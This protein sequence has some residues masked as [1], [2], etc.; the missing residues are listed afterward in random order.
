MTLT[1]RTSIPL[2]L[3]I[4]TLS[5]YSQAAEPSGQ[6]SASGFFEG[7]SLSLST[8]NFAA[9]ERFQGHSGLNIPKDGG[10]QFTQSR[11]TWVQGT[12]LKYNSG[13]T[14]GTVGFGID[15]AAFNAINLER[16]KGRIAGGGNRTLADSNGHGQEHW[17][18]LGIANLRARISRSELKV[19]RF[20]VETPV[21]NAIDNRALPSSFNGVGLVSEELDNLNLQAGSFRRT[22]P[23]TGAGDEALTTEYGTRQAEGER[24]N[25][26]GGNYKALDNLEV[27]LYGGR[28]E[29]IWDQYY[30]GITHDLGDREQLSLRTAF[31]GYHTR[32][33]GAREAGYIDNNTW[34]LAFTLGHQAHGLTLA[35]QQV[36]GDEYF[37]YVHETSA[38]YL[39]NSLLSDY[40][41]PNEKSAQIRYETDWSYFGIPGLSTMAW[42]A[43]GW[44]I[45]GTHYD[46]GRNGAHANYADVLSQDGEKHRE[47]GL[48]ASY[49]VQSGAIKDSTF[50]VTYMSHK[51]SQNQADGS[52]NEL[53]IVSTL[54]FDLL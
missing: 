17:S 51:A 39:A 9:R 38:I 32:D 45:D 15:V 47:Y 44:D 10:A 1:L 8:R 41:G 42:Y 24:Y 5:S 6:D 40:N 46:G 22:S 4:L 7:Q 52:V 2:S 28:F 16:G 25:Y 36:E 43:K 18:K 34:S 26:L 19:G 35:W 23:R 12:Q 11:Y 31:N 48:M 33:S 20:Q 27:A 37:D 3:A 29:D 13:Y 50:K 30:L 21:F 14:Q 49:K 54:P 53:R